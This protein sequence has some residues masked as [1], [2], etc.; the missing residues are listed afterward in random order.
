MLTIME[1]PNVILTSEC[2]YTWE[3][4]PSSGKDL[5]RIMTLPLKNVFYDAITHL[6]LKISHFLLPTA[7]T[8]QLS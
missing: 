6:I 5:K 4:L 3:C 8:L 1:K 2:V 7:M